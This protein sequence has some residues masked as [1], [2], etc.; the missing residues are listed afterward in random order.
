MAAECADHSATWALYY[1]FNILLPKVWILCVLTIHTATTHHFYLCL[2]IIS[3]NTS[4]FMDNSN[5]HSFI[6][7]GIIFIFTILTINWISISNFQLLLLLFDDV[8]ETAAISLECSCCS[9]RLVVERSTVLPAV[10]PNHQRQ[11]TP[12]TD[13]NHCL[14]S[15]FLHL[16]WTR[17]RVRANPNPNQCLASSFLHLQWTRV[18]VRA[19]PNPNH[20]LA[21]SFLH[22]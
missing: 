6:V 13:P 3:V 4:F 10:P 20:C 9:W 14:A 17:V 1:H 16:Q 12:T 11:I 2:K 18:R 19:N 21:S 22:L 7:P 8:P 15:S 5:L